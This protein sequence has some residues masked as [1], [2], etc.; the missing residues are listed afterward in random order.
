MVHYPA[1]NKERQTDRKPGQ[2]IEALLDAYPSIQIEPMGNSMYPMMLP[3]RDKAILK[4]ADGSKLKKGDVV[5]YRRDNG[6]LVLHRLA[7]CRP[8]GL[9]LVG[10]NQSELEGPLQR[11]QIKGVLTAFIRK[12]RC[13]KA[14]NPIYRT[15][16]LLW[17][18]LLP[19]R[20]PL[21]RILAFF[22]G[23]KR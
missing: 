1:E 11:E 10:D 5:L 22:R 23:D 21:H 16:A 17:L 19:I 2:R 15:A 14:T 13:I 6:M 12:G 4:K 18:V 9:Y 20:T 3:G 8:E 7:H